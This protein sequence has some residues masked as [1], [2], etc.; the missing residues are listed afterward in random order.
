MSFDY[1]NCLVSSHGKCIYLSFAD[2]KISFGHRVKYHVEDDIVALV[3]ALGLYHRIL[4]L[5]VF[6]VSDV[7]S[8]M[9]TINFI[10]GY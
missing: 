2:I 5:I 10:E 9:E 4:G 1:N 8:A 7:P 3:T 6:L